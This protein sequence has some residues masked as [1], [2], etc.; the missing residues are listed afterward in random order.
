MS[1][2]IKRFL[3]VLSPYFLHSNTFK[4]LEYFIRH[5]RYIL[6][7][8]IRV[9]EYDVDHVMSC[10]IAYHETRQFVKVVSILIISDNSQWAF[11][12]A[13]QKSQSPLDRT[14]LIRKCI[15]DSSLTSFILNTVEDSENMGINH[16]SLTTFLA[17]TM[18]DLIQTKQEITENDLS[19]IIPRVLSFLKHKNVNL[20]AAVVMI[21]NQLSSKCIFDAKLLSLIIDKLAAVLD[22]GNLAFMIPGI[23][24]LVQAQNSKICLS[25]KI[26]ETI[27]NVDGGFEA[28]VSLS[29]KFNAE[30]F[31]TLL[32]SSCL[33]ICL[34]SQDLKTLELMKK[35]LSGLKMDSLVSEHF[36]DLLLMKVKEFDG[37]FSLHVFK[38]VYEVVPDALNNV[39]SKYFST[40][41]KSEK[42]TDTIFIFAQKALEGTLAEPLASSGTSLL[43]SLEHSQTHI[44]TMAVKKLDDVLLKKDQKLL[45]AK[46]I[47]RL[48]LNRLNDEEDV[49]KA[50]LRIKNLDNFIAY[51]PL[52]EVLEKIIWS[53]SKP[54]VVISAMKALV[55]YYKFEADHQIDVS[56]L[57]ICY[58]F[59]F[60]SKGAV[61]VAE[62]LILNLRK[63]QPK[64][65]SF[66]QNN[67]LYKYKDSDPVKCNHEILQ[68]LAKNS[69]NNLE[70]VLI[71]VE[72]AN[73]RISF[74]FGAILNQCILQNNFTPTMRE[75]ILIAVERNAF[76]YL[77]SG[78]KVDGNLDL[79]QLLSS[80]KI[81]SAEMRH[82]SVLTLKN[83]VANFL[84]DSKIVRDETL[85]IFDHPGSIFRIISRI[86][87]Q[88]LN[89]QLLIVFFTYYKGSSLELCCSQIMNSECSS[90]LSILS[91]KVMA[92][93]LKSLDSQ[94]DAQLLIPVVLSACYHGSRKVRLLAFQIFNILRNRYISSPLA[95]HSFNICG[96]KTEM[97]KLLSTEKVSFL[98]ASVLERRLEI[99]E[100]PSKLSSIISRISSDRYYNLKLNSSNILSFLISCM[101]SSADM[102][103]NSCLLRMLLENDSV[104]KFKSLFPTISQLSS[105]KDITQG[106]TDVLLLL[107]SCYS[108]K[109][110]KFMNSTQSARYF[111]GFI[112]L[113]SI[114]ALPKI[115]EKVLEMVTQ[116]FFENLNVTQQIELVKKLYEILG[117]GD[118]HLVQISKTV[119]NSLQLSSAHIL[120]LLTSTKMKIVPVVEDRK[121]P[122][123][124]DGSPDA[125]MKIFTL[126]LEILDSKNNIDD[127]QD[128]IMPLF[129]I[130]KDTLT[131]EANLYE[132]TKQLLLSIINEVFLSLNSS[133]L[134]IGSE[135]IQI[136]TLL[137]CI[138]VT[139]NIQSHNLVFSCLSNVACMHPQ[140]VLTSVMPIFTFMGTNVLRQDDDF[141]FFIIRKTI[142]SIVPVLVKDLAL[143]GDLESVLDVFLKAL[144]HIPRHRRLPIYKILIDELGSQMF[145]GKVL[146]KILDS[147]KTENLNFSSQLIAEFGIHIQLDV[148]FLDFI[149]RL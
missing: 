50:V 57:Q 142:T 53:H 132:Y 41:D 40:M 1:A 58:C 20:Q 137:Q 110:A 47:Q 147:E 17:C 2:V 43:L 125:T 124:E 56:V 94:Q 14:N 84:D 108:P 32:L 63:Y 140:L 35:L 30:K 82:L 117:H 89:I 114:D 148:S 115:I 74:V 16:V 99:V 131:L 120:P 7:L 46:D 129:D 97:V 103:L 12:K 134:T 98:I 19:L 44:R 135:L 38:S 80:A 15:G 107:V 24:V 5:F 31:M 23:V 121:K 27:K 118:S 77:G 61:L 100:D 123:I 42:E 11:L 106:Q 102:Y 128:L 149:S 37:D 79:E 72:S 87:N 116:E 146:L 145:L 101:I 95:C 119:L 96:L 60:L 133:N 9:H 70:A 59:S 122:K 66:L 67:Q 68:S 81:S 51:K 73:Q 13:V 54:K 105:L 113:L 76:Q 90:D 78:S 55:K 104:D 34:N 139:D 4:V 18:I 45:S 6:L 126:L 28:L 65:L 109:I 22:Q 93:Y 64:Y 136:D 25:A 21:I 10:I 144:H 29:G 52:M 138:R 112:K 69:M 8:I 130:L 127:S 92:A 62:T 75:K 26:I 39:L 71:S 141:S 49:I 91:L 48:L 33:S 88:D 86:P 83:M 143:H 85:D 111:S 3:G 36:S